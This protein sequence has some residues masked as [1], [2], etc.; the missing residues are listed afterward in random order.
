LIG[1]YLYVPELGAIV[2]QD[3]NIVDQDGKVIQIIKGK[4]KADANH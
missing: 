4:G 1:R 3:G 2:D